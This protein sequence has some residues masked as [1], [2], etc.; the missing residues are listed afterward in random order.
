MKA[1]LYIPA[2]VQEISIIAESG[3]KYVTISSGCC[4]SLYDE[5]IVIY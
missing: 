2:M 4:N 1:S 5:I 3:I